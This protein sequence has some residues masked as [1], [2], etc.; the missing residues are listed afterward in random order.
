MRAL[1]FTAAYLLFSFA[2]HADEPEPEIFAPMTISA[3]IVA[4]G[5]AFSADQSVVI[6]ERGEGHHRQLY[7]SHREGE[8]W[9]TPQP[10]PFEGPWNYLE[11]TLSS[12]GS[13]LIFASNRPIDGGA[14][15]TDGYWAG[16]TQVGLGGTLWR[17][18]RTATGWAAPKPLPALI[19]ST[20]S[21]FN[22]AQSGNGTLYYMQTAD[23]DK[24]FHL[25][26]AEKKGDGYAKPERLPF[27]LAGSADVDPAVASDDSFLIFASP[28]ETPGKLR[29]FI[30]YHTRDGGWTPPKRLPGKINEGGAATDLHL[31]PDDRTLY[32]LRNL[33]IWQVPIAE[34]VKALR[35]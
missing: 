33:V 15:P 24:K 3:P 8:G 17:S 32:F 7:Q 5:P 27:F 25:M 4:T 2:A 34:T 19:N 26:R 10:L 14:T 31:S 20:T 12:D 18:D 30:S 21:I 9:A 6:F 35:D 11:P 29:L 13:Y 16:K 1:I 23:E 22:P 28:R